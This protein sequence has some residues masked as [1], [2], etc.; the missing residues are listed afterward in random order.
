M[1]SAKNRAE[2]KLPIVGALFDSFGVPAITAPVTVTFDALY[3]FV[4]GVVEVFE[5]DTLPVYCYNNITEAYW[6]I[7][8]NFIL[9]G[10]NLAY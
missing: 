6:A 3:G 8:R 7:N 9:Q 4:R 1:R 10:Y 5:E 2:K